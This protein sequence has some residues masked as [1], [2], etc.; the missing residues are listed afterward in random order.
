MTVKITTNENNEEIITVK[1]CLFGI[2]ITDD[3]N[4]NIM[5]IGNIFSEESI[6]DLK[7]NVI[8]KKIS[9]GKFIQIFFYDHP[10]L[11]F[12]NKIFDGFTGMEIISFESDQVK[13]TVTA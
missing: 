4:N 3:Q 2:K 13:I 9:D 10:E 1:P 12:V 8:Q 6:S 11:D 7:T 5:S